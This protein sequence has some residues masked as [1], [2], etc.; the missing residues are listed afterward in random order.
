MSLLR[1]Y[2]RTSV[3]PS[4]VGIL[5]SLSRVDGYIV[6]DIKKDV[7]LAINSIDEKNL[8]WRDTVWSYNWC[9]ILF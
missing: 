6:Q 9:V 8:N 2:V 3:I 5:D 7:F 4:T 1:T